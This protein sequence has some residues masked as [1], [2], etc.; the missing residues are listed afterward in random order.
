MKLARPEKR[1]PL[2]P[3]T[4]LINVVFL[5][6]IFFMLTGTIA[7]PDLLNIRPPLS[8]AGQKSEEPGLRILLSADGTLAIDDKRLAADAIGKAA[9]AFLDND[10]GGRIIVAADGRT[11]A[12]RVLDLLDT[13]RA[14]GVNRVSLVTAGKPGRGTR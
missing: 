11:P 2:E 14:A 7:T 10:P 1:R 9:K 12:G 8:T 13:L 5:L 4:P 3:L 6:L